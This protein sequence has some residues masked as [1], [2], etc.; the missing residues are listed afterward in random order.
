M[1]ILIQG[2]LNQ[3]SINTISSYRRYGEVVV[4]CYSSDK[5]KV[6]TKYLDYADFIFLDEPVVNCANYANIFLQSYSTY[7]G[8]SAC[9]QEFVI[10]TR[11]DESYPNLD[12]FIETMIENPTKWI[13]NNI[14]FKSVEKEWLH[15]GDHLIGGK[16][17]Y[18]LNTFLQ[19][20][21]MCKKYTNPQLQFTIADFG[22]SSMLS[23]QYHSGCLFPENV[24]FL[25]FLKTIYKDNFYDYLITNNTIDGMK[26]IMREHTALVNLKDIT[27]YIWSFIYNANKQSFT[28]D[29]VALNWPGSPAIQSI[30]DV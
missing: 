4:A 29:E 27:P 15:P 5:D 10:K 28:S 6:G 23:G 17:S 22:F 16:T 3:I 12:K 30:R 11:S 2:P 8:L 25:N 20:I 18:L 19:T 9:N 1:N 24:L 14:W 7:H 26:N 13:S 21:Q